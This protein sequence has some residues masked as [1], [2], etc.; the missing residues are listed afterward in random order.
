M[1]EHAVHFGGTEIAV[2]VAVLTRDGALATG[3]KRFSTTRAA[4]G[5]A[6]E[7]AFVMVMKLRISARFAQ[8]PMSL[9]IGAKLRPCFRAGVAGVMRQHLRDG[10]GR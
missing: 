2:R 6:A 9:T 1:R 3:R 10:A 4:I 5:R 7:I 8:V